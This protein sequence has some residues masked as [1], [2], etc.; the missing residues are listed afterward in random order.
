LVNVNAIDKAKSEIDNRENI[1][2]P[3]GEGNL[4]HIFDDEKD[5]RLK[6]PNP[7]TFPTKDLLKG[8]FRTRLEK[9]D[10]DMQKK[11]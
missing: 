6:V 7:E 11:I 8:E 2:F 9:N 5:L 10:R 4:F 1:Y 3:V